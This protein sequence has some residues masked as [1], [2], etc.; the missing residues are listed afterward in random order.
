MQVTAEPFPKH[1]RI[2]SPVLRLNR[3]RHPLGVAHVEVAVGHAQNEAVGVRR[4]PLAARDVRVGKHESAHELHVVR[5]VEKRHATFRADAETPI[6]RVE[7]HAPRGHREASIAHQ[8]ARQV[9]LPHSHAA[10][11][12][13][14]EKETP[15]VAE[16]HV[17]HGLRV[18]QQEALD[19]RERRALHARSDGGFA[20]SAT[21]GPDRSRK[22][23]R[24]TRQR[25][26]GEEQRCR[27]D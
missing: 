12:A 14:R 9:R 15:V 8:A 7:T 23:W 5:V 2:T 19:S 24:T 22:T 18:A 27:R 25:R 17:G 1:C 4:H 6:L 16:A 10:V 13:A 11:D 20:G 3:S 26:C 21:G